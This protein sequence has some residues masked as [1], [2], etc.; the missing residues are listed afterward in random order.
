MRHRLQRIHC[1]KCETAN[2]PESRACRRCAAPLGGPTQTRMDALHAA[3]RWRRMAAWIVD[4][5][6]SP[7]SFAA[8]M[9]AADQGGLAVVTLT[10]LLLGIVGVPTQVILLG[11]HGQTVGKRLFGIRIVDQETGVTSGAFTN[12]VLRYFVNW[13]LTLIPPYFAIDHFFIFARNRR[14]LHDYLAGTKVVLDSSRT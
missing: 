7:A 11:R 8:G 12:V 3:E 1:P 6:I 2:T 10:L 4:L 13:L 14:C 9:L 5:P